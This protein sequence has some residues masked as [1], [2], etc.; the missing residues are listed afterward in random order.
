MLDVIVSVMVR[1]G[2]IFTLAAHPYFLPERLCP[3]QEARNRDEPL[4][5]FERAWCSVLHPDTP[6]DPFWTADERAKHASDLGRGGC[7]ISPP[8]AQLA[9]FLVVQKMLDR[10]PEIHWY[11]DGEKDLAKAALVACRDRIIA[12]GQAIRGAADERAAPLRSAEV[13]LYQHD[14]E[15]KFEKGRGEKCVRKAWEDAEKRLAE[16]EMPAA[17]ELQ[18]APGASDPKVRAGLYR[19]AFQGGFS[20]KGDWGWLRYPRDATLYRNCRTLWLTRMPRKTFESHGRAALSGASLQPVDSIMDSMR[21]RVGSLERPRS[22]AASGNAYRSSAATPGPAFEEL[23]AYLLR[24]NY[25]IRKKSERPIIPATTWGLLGNKET[26]P[27]LIDIAWKFRLSVRHAELIS[28][29][30]RA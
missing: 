19:L 18:I 11:I 23:T 5:G 8:Y 2:K 25:F 27:S 6:E 1:D 16:K 15:A 24:Q 3:N 12:G 4:P 13:V 30:L 17:G 10:F 22:R 7:F 14:T 20:E 9:H 21:E 29:W 28:R 26:V